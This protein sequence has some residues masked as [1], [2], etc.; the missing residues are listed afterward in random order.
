MF[1]RLALRC[2][3]SPRGLRFLQ[4]GPVAAASRLGLFAPLS[5]ALAHSQ[6][7][8]RDLNL[9]AQ[10]ETK[11]SRPPEFLEPSIVTPYREAA[12]SVSLQHALMHVVDL[13]SGM[14]TAARS[15]GVPAAELKAAN[16]WTLKVLT[17]TTSTVHCGNSEIANMIR[18]GSLIEGDLAVVV[19]SCGCPSRAGCGPRESVD[20]SDKTVIELE[21]FGSV[22]GAHAR[23]NRLEHNNVIS[24]KETLERG[25]KGGC[26]FD[27]RLRRLRPPA[28]D[29]QVAAS[30]HDI[31]HQLSQEVPEAK[32][33]KE[34]LMRV[35]RLNLQILTDLDEANVS[36]FGEPRPT[37]HHTNLRSLTSKTA[38]A[39]QSGDLHKVIM[40]LGNGVDNEHE[41]YT[42]LAESAPSG[43][44]TLSTGAVENGFIDHTFDFRSVDS[45]KASPILRL[46]RLHDS[47]TGMVFLESLAKECGCTVKDL[48]VSVATT[49]DNEEDTAILLA[50]LGMGLKNI[51]AGPTHP[52]YFTPTMVDYLSKE[53]PLNIL[54]GEPQIDMASIISGQKQ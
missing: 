20:L 31:F 34:L 40:L 52:I 23:T 8:R 2:C 49:H 51:W 24:M 6:Q 16:Q 22:L 27:E 39:L 7:N 14:A 48:P 50:L 28:D 33:M 10:Y 21:A 46:G 53:L 4:K 41:Y 29:D 54:T 47:Y 18:E 42:A 11:K 43:S 38:Q 25:L 37:R 30:I 5:T 9:N 17:S 19:A 45:K 35:G 12:T 3:A 1:P 36:R 26:V 13:V 15:V 32:S 44:I